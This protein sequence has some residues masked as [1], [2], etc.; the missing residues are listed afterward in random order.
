MHVLSPVRIGSNSLYKFKMIQMLSQ[1]DI[2]VILSYRVAYSIQVPMIC[3]QF[4]DFWTLKILSILLLKENANKN[5]KNLK[6]LIIKCLQ[7]QEQLNSCY[8]ILKIQ[9]HNSWVQFS[10]QL[11]I[12]EGMLWES[13]LFLLY[14]TLSVD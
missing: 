5:C 8:Q 4:H 12:S 7:K 10:Y 11:L 13:S 6:Y 2:F 3:L 9:Y 1:T 14:F